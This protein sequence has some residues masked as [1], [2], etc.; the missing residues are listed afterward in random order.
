[1]PNNLT[2]FRMYLASDT[3]NTK[4]TLY[5]NMVEI[6][7]AEE[8]AKACLKDHVC[9]E[10]KNNKR[11]SDNFIKCHAIQ[12]DCDNDNTEDA[13]AWITPDIVATRLSGIAF[14]AV[15]SRN[16]DRVKHPGSPREKSARPRWHYYF[17]LRKA[18]PDINIISKIMN[19]LLVLFPEFDRDGMKPAQFFFGHAKP[20]AE[21]HPGE[22]DI[23]EFFMDHPEITRRVASAETKPAEPPQRGLASGSRDD[24]ITMNAPDMLAM[25]PADD[26][27]IWV[28]VG[29]A[30]KAAGADPS[31]WDGWSQTSVKYPG[32]TA[33]IQKW[34]SFNGSGKGPG[35]LVHLAQTYGWK[36]DP[37][38]LT[39]EYKANHEAAEAYK[40]R[41]YVPDNVQPIAGKTVI[42]TPPPSEAT[43]GNKPI[44][45]LVTF[46][47]DYFNNTDIPEPEPI[48]DKILFPG[49][50]MLGAPAKM[51]KTY[52]VLQLGCCVATG[53][54]F[55]G[56]DVLRSGPVLYLDLQGTLARTKKRLHDIGYQRMPDGLE[57]AYKTRT[58]DSG[59][60]EQLERW[61]SAQSQPPVLIIIDMLQQVKGAQRKTEDSY[62]ADNRILEPLHDLAMKH[63]LC[64]FCVM[65]T[66]KGNKILPDDDPFNEILGSIGQFGSADCSWMIIGRRTDDKKRFSVICRDSDAGQVDYE[67]TF[68]D[69][70]WSIAGTVEDCEEMR[71]IARYNQNPIV[72]TIRKLVEE[73]PSGWIGTMSD[74]MREVANR[75]SQYPA[76]SPEKMKRQVTSVEYRLHCEGILIE[77]V[78]PNGG[79]GGRRYKVYKFQPKQQ[80]INC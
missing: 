80:S 35:T 66:R 14:Y 13:S 40:A 61:I 53:Q 43:T 15:K 52:M 48:I 10:F 72:F 79:K 59:L 47:A 69:H 22:K 39:G 5:N 63:K 27:G 57:L 65:H 68:R 42:T 60:I 64:V 50:G 21:Y 37:E 23:A 19:S 17:P 7:S 67:A 1:M 41:M 77:L 29:M 75:T 20:A 2:S 8:L 30:L 33:I 38:K 58:T 71:E 31:L 9:T 55:M 18:I 45:D 36:A 6:S 25:I 74:L 4:N 76:D 73:S 70:R 46:N 12:A 11:G 62:T 78:N 49:L 16:C 28:D 56:F 32:H 54:P 26:Y 24:F 44:P 3:G 34:N 51:G